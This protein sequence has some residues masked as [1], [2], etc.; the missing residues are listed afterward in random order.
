M[1]PGESLRPLS[2]PTFGPTQVASSAMAF[3]IQTACVGCAMDLPKIS[4]GFTNS[5]QVASGLQVFY[6]CCEAAPNPALA[7]ACLSLQFSLSHAPPC[8]A[9]VADIL[10]SVPGQGTITGLGLYQRPQNQQ[11]QWPASDHTRVP[12]NH[13]HILRTQRE[14]SAGTR[15]LLKRILLPGVNTCTTL[16]LL[17]SWIVPT[18]NQLGSVPPIDEPTAMKGQLQQESAPYLHRRHTWSTWIR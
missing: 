8:P 4:Q 2:H 13:L 12:L 11:T 7:A 1:L 15:A 14:D 18:T 16:P 6:T 9:Q 17:W 3:S 10:H 5:K